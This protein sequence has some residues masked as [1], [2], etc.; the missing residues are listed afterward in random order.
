MPTPYIPP[1]ERGMMFVEIPKSYALKRGD[2]SI[3]LEMTVQDGSALFYK[4][5]AL[6]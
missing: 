4:V 6:L 2:F 3:A 5:G 1:P